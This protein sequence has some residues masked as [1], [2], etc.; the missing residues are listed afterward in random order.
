MVFP[1][2]PAADP[3]IYQGAAVGFLILGFHYGKY[4]TSL[5]GMLEI[6]PRDQN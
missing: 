6:I 2:D 5:T 4:A 1:T 3:V